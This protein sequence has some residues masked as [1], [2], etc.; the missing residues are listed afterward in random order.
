M[1]RYS[2]ELETD[3]N[4]DKKK[5]YMIEIFY[6]KLQIYILPKVRYHLCLKK[7][8]GVFITRKATISDFRRKVAE[9]LHDNKNDE[10]TVEELMNLARLWR[11]EI[12]ENVKEI[13]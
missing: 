1:P 5:Q 9:I 4:E 10:N 11:L 8:S 12:G 13:E 2:I 3:D 6:K 7:P